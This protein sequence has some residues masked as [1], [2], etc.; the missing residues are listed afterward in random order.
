MSEDVP[1]N[2]RSKS[3]CP[4]CVWFTDMPLCGACPLL[5]PQ[6]LLP[7]RTDVEIED[8]KLLEQH[9]I[10]AERQLG[11]TALTVYCLPR[12]TSD[13]AHASCR[14]NS[15]AAKAA[16]T[17]AT[18]A[19]SGGSKSGQPAAGDGVDGGADG[20]NVGLIRG[21][22][23]SLTDQA[24]QH[25]DIAEQQQQ[26]QPLQQDDIYQATEGS[27]DSDI[28]TPAAEATETA[29]AAAAA[30]GAHVDPAAD[31]SG[32][33]HHH[34]YAPAYDDPSSAAVVEPG[35]TLEQGAVT[36]GS[37]AADLFSVVS[38]SV[39]VS[40]PLLLPEN[41]WQVAFAEDSYSVSMLDAGSFT[42]KV[43]RISYTSFTTPDSVID[44][45]LY[46]QRK[47]TR[48]VKAVKGGFQQERYRSYRLWASAPDG[49][50]VPLSL[51]YRLDKFGR[52]GLN[53]ALLLV[54]GAYGDKYDPEFDS[55]LLTL[56]DRGWVVGIAH[57][58]GGG[59]LGHA[60][61][62]DGRLDRK[63]NTFNDL[64]AC[65]RT[66]ID[67]NI[68]SAGRL[69]L[70]GRSAG[71]L[72]LGAAVNEEPQLFHSVIFDVPFLDVLSDM[73]D[74]RLP[75]TVKE[76][77]EWGN[78]ITNATMAAYMASYSPVDNIKPQAYPHML[79]T[80]GLNDRRV[81]YW[82]PAKWVAKL[83][84]MKTDD[85]LLLLHVDMG[86]GHFTSSISTGAMSTTAMKY[87]FLIATLPSCGLPGGLTSASPADVTM[88]QHP[89]SPAPATANTSSSTIWAVLLPVLLP[90]VMVLIAVSGVASVLWH[91]RRLWLPAAQQEFTKHEVQ[92][93]LLVGLGHGEAP[94]V[95]ATASTQTELVELQLPVRLSP[96]GRQ[97]Q[98]R[99][100]RRV[101]ITGL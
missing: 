72:T 58:R 41:S 47:T 99:L 76:W 12:N 90:F 100:E 35:L 19:A 52:N 79:V 80:G 53:P 1:H 38:Q 23:G 65:A 68:T 45:N 51:V 71:G 50:A 30:A 97:H 62:A 2:L 34:R 13:A 7:H 88:T 84:S 4:A 26:Q 73:S 98:N 60:W 32:N 56:L 89:D 78:P 5:F 29:E 18:A 49:V 83:R 81:N 69:A 86:G 93:L 77:E 15:M 59:E 96:S 75:L 74:A 82:E 64:I 9:L 55:G 42:S 27:V 85:H 91:N 10:L 39:L 3:V 87:S 70:W 33:S 8:F 20:R 16:E 94:R 22:A 24:Q 66:L 6:V 48:S 36:R 43:L 17:A 31:N 46:T 61:H 25:L 95:H 40:P 67:Q 101:S 37:S 54:Y 11:H 63:K 44:I 57:V 28:S 92:P 14:Y 21:R